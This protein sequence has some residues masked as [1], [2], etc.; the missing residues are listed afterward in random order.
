MFKHRY[1]FEW[2]LKLNRAINRQKN[3]K[4]SK[5]YINKFKTRLVNHWN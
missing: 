4:Y 1:Y 3:N 5:S 2:V